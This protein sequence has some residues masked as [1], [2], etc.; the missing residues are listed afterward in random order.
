MPGL[1]LPIIDALVH[2]PIALLK[3]V[4]LPAN[5]YT[6]FQV[7]NPPQNA[8]LYLTY[9]LKFQIHFVPP[10]YG[11]FGTFPVLYDDSLAIVTASYIDGSGFGTVR[12]LERIT[13]TNQ[14]FMWEEPLP[15]A[16][17][18]DIAPGVTF[19]LYWMQT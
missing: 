5:P 14:D 7:L 12:Q 9:G 3:R 19:D 4:A 8:I 1:S 15:S 18:V 6:N 13:Y 11:H 16:V 10:Q 2:P 17:S